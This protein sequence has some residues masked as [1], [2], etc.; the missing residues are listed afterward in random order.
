MKKEMKKEKTYSIPI[1]IDGAII[2]VYSTSKN[3]VNLCY[4]ALVFAQENFVLWN[5]F[6]NIKEARINRKK[7]KKK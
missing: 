7:S 1:Q 5:K 6:L 2:D 4:D 3:A